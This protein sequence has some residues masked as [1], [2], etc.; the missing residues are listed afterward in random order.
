M[1]FLQIEV[2]LLLW[3][4][5]AKN[6]RVLSSG[7]SCHM[8]FAALHKNRRSVVVDARNIDCGI[9]LDIKEQRLNA[10]VCPHEGLL[11]VA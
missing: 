2:L 11:T 6:C 9:L 8:C 5:P 4:R 1:L 7:E 10:V 3:A